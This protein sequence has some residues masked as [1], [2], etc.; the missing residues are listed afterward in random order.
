VRGGTQE[1]IGLLA[2]AEVVTVRRKQSAKPMAMP[3]P[4]VL[5]ATDPVC[6][7]TVDVATA[8]HTRVHGGQTFYFCCA[9]CQAE[10]ERDPSKYLKAV[11]A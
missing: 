2:L 3:P 9:G 6:G 11:E 4:K 1:E 5:F 10:F 7:M 8:A